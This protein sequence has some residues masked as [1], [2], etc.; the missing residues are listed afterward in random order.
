MAQQ[1]Q[2]TWRA[3]LHVETGFAISRLWS[4]WIAQTIVPCGAGR[5]F[6][7]IHQLCTGQFRL[8]VKV[9]GIWGGVKAGQ[10]LF[11]KTPQLHRRDLENRPLGQVTARQSLRNDFHFSSLNYGGYY[12]FLQSTY[13]FPTHRRP[14]HDALWSIASVR[15]NCDIKRR[16]ASDWRKGNRRLGHGFQKTVLFSTLRMR[17]NMNTI[18]TGRETDPSARPQCVVEWGQ[19]GNVILERG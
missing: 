5:S 12:L 18:K 7:I 19:A 1:Q 11:Y 6:H 8:P 15:F 3:F 16:S 10:V 9:V 2:Q 14:T 17:Q 4:T 13:S